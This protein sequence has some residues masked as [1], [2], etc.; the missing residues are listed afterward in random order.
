MSVLQGAATSA[1]YDPITPVSHTRIADDFPVVNIGAN[2][3][4]HAADDIHVLG[5]S[6]ITEVSTPLDIQDLQ[7]VNKSQGRIMSEVDITNVGKTELA[8]E[9][10]SDDSDL[11][12]EDSK[13]DNDTEDPSEDVTDVMMKPEEIQ[14]CESD[15]EAL[16]ISNDSNSCYEC[17]GRL[18]VPEGYSYRCTTCSDCDICIPCFEDKENHAHHRSQVHVFANP[19]DA[20]GCNSCGL[21]FDHHAS[22][23]NK[24]QEYVLCKRC[25]HQSMHNHHA[26][27]LKEMTPMEYVSVIK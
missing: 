21:E 10:S 11:S 25:M 24:C 17:G 7:Y 3:H 26:N 16:D 22:K 23:C 2:E 4:D 20:R 5:L 18:K 12:T 6:S 15:T 13:A 14:I 1:V 27:F 8:H 9:S 19:C